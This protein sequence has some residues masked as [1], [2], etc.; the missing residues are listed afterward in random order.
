[1]NKKSKNL[2]V[3][4]EKLGFGWVG[5]KM[6]NLGIWVAGGEWVWWRMA[7]SGVSVVGEG[8]GWWGFLDFMEDLRWGTEKERG[9]GVRPK[10]ENGEKVT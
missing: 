8:D 9:R 3:F 2:G 7:G 5:D 10:G 6:G 4:L 1:L